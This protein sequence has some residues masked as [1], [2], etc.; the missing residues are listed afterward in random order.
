MRPLACLRAAAPGGA[1]HADTA[2][3]GP[4]RTGAADGA[5]HPDGAVSADGRVCGTYLHGLFDEAAFRAAFLNRLRAAAG[6]PARPPAVRGSEI[7][8]LADHVEAHLDMAR[9]D[10]IVGLAPR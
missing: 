2:G 10:A 9:L 8:R 1:T 3:R 7:E 4:E 5:T 6:L